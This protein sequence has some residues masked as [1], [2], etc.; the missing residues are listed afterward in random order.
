MRIPIHKHFRSSDGASLFY[1]YWPAESQPSSRA[2]VLFHRG[3]EHSG[4][5]QHVVDEL[6]LPDYTM[7][8]WDA[9]GHGL[10]F[11]AHDRSQ[12]SLGTFVK[13]VDCFVRHIASVHGIAPENIAA[14]GQS[15]GAV[16]L[17]TWAHDYAPKIR[18]MT[19][20]APAFAVK[21]Y[22][23]RARP[24]L[25]LAR[26]VAGEF[27]VNSYVKAWQLSHD[28]SRIASY[29]S[30]PL[31]RRPIAV[32]V[33]LAL[34]GTASRVIQDAHAIRVPTQVLI[35]GLDFVVKRK[36]QFDFFNNLGS[37]VKELHEFPGFY[38]DTLGELDRHL[39]I[40]KTREFITRR[41]AEPMAAK[42]L[43]EAD[44]SGET[45]REF[46]ALCRPLPTASLRNVFFRL[47]RRFLRR[48]AWFSDGLRL[49]FDTG[50]DSGST[51][52]YVYRNQPSGRTPLG[53]F[54]DRCYLNSIGWRGIRIRRENVE[55]LL[56]EAIAR[57]RGS[58]RPV[59]ILDVAAGRGRYCLAAI[60]EPEV[61]DRIV[62]RDNSERNVLE[63]R[64]L[65]R[66]KGLGDV[67][68]FERA[69]A[70]CREEV[71]G[72][73]PRPTVGVVSGLYELFPENAPLQESLAGL[74]D[75]VEPGGYLVYTGQ[76]WHPQLEMI[77]RVLPSHRGGPWV[78]RR[79]TQAEL[80][81]LVESAGFRKI[82]Q[83]TDDWGI[84]TA[85]L[86]QRTS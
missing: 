76:P 13:D 23:P 69:D 28:P 9:R 40:G 56:R 21:L 52:D 85:S 65:I 68:V 27:P 67:A 45:K 6:D 26:A 1:R 41:F 47:S 29:E 7:F 18:A 53:R 77:A 62:L 61:G 25:A 20:A 31:I 24:A 80:D 22:V 35:S 50:F 63:G 60:G 81:Q 4:R 19:L 5:L 17:A 66:E 58:E 16:L 64:E 15:V 48:G 42:S 54:I 59:R 8:A 51:L 12:P 83:L 86:A 71:A 73:S 72:A 78:M 32:K 46:D 11:N 55:R 79:R 82:D 10:S 33:L 34:Y 2:I 43:L 36:P 30:D 14:I 39:A 44:C 70:F 3:H 37:P 74:A 49:G 38:H 57:L 75:A 84:F